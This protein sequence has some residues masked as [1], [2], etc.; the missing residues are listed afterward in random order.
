LPAPSF[1]VNIQSIG[2]NPNMTETILLRCPHCGETFEA[3]IDASEADA[4][5][6]TDCEVCCRPMSVTVKITNTEAVEVKVEKP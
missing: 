3:A 6:I 5:F 2:T 4:Q 1:S